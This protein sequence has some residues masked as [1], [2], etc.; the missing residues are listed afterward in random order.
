MRRAISYLI[1]VLMLAA[2]LVVYLRFVYISPLQNQTS[3]E[4]DSGDSAR[5]VA[6]KIGRKNLAHQGIALIAMIMNGAYKSL[7]VGEYQF[8]QGL[9]IEEMID[10]ITKA[11]FRVPYKLTVIEGM[12]V[13]QVAQKLID[14]DILNGQ[15][16]DFPKEG[17]VYPDTY[18]V[19]KGDQRHVLLSKMEQKMQS[20]LYDIWNERDMTLPLNS[21]EELLIVASI[22]EKETDVDRER[23]IIAGVF[24]N[25]LRKGMLLQ[26]DPTVI[27]ALTQGRASLGRPLGKQDLLA[28]LPHNTYMYK[29]LPPGPIAIPSVRSLIAAAHPAQTKALYFVATGSGGHIFSESLQQHVVHHQKLRALRKKNA[30]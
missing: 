12:T 15:I 6:R 8:P 21:P 24:Y 20:A 25:R 23:A 18:T 27:Y 14:Q 10:A 11:H 7:K 30:I 16:K 26:S 5:S 9:S 28:K 2:I 22:V 1:I 19:Y 29:G 13:A 3:M 17:L 4:V